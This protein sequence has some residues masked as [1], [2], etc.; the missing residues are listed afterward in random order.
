MSLR[1]YRQASLFSKHRRNDSVP[2]LCSLSNLCFLA[3][4]IALTVLERALHSLLTIEAS[5]LQLLSLDTVMWKSCVISSGHDEII[6]CWADVPTHFRFWQ[7]LSGKLLLCKMLNHSFCFI[8]ILFSLALS[9]LYLS[10]LIANILI[11]IIL[12]CSHHALVE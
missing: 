3:V 12:N 8:K 7:Q 6:F 10:S 1:P 4:C 2:S 5:L 11:V 9:T